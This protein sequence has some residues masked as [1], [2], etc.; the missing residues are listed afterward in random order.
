MIPEAVL[1][2]GFTYLTKIL[3]KVGKSYLNTEVI[4]TQNVFKIFRN[5]HKDLI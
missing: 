3:F 1:A 5:V 2:S 4:E